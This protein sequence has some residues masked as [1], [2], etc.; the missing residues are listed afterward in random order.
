MWSGASAKP[1]TFRNNLLN[2]WSLTDQNKT[3]APKNT[4]VVSKLFSW[5]K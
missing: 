2:D 3:E 1:T 5:F 4:S